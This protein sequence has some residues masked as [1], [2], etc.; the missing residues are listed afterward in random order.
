MLDIECLVAESWKI[1]SG[2]WQWDYLLYGKFCNFIN[3]LPIEK[4]KTK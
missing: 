4:T 2:Y 3:D 1:V